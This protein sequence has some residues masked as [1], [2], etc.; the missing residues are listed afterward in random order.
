MWNWMCVIVDK[1]LF[2]YS[3]GIELPFQLRWE[4]EGN[5]EPHAKT[6]LNLKKLQAS[7]NI[8]HCCQIYVSPSASC[9]YLPLVKRSPGSIN[10][11]VKW[12]AM[13]MLPIWVLHT[14]SAAPHCCPCAG[15]ALHQ[16]S[17]P[18][19]ASVSSHSAMLNATWVRAHWKLGVSHHSE[20]KD[21]EMA[22]NE[23]VA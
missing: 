6:K 12:W 23:G 16:P 14:Q 9:F 1:T 11:Y 22:W 17:F 5:L 18:S 7:Q 19:R 8:F 21:D 15:A 3:K 13:R 20:D 2:D 4:E 10:Q